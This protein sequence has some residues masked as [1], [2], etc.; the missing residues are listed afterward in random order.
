MIQ[1]RK[2]SHNTSQHQRTSFRPNVLLDASAN[3]NRPSK[4]VHNNASNKPTRP[5]TKALAAPGAPFVLPKGFE[6]LKADSEPKVSKL[7][8]QSKLAG[9]Q[10]WYITAP[11]SLPITSIKSVALKDVQKGKP[12]ATINGQSYGFQ[13]DEGP[14]KDNAKLLV[15]SRE[16]GRY[17]TS[18][19]GIDKVLHLQQIV[20]LPE[21]MTE[22]RAT[23]P[24]ASKF[25]RQQPKGLRMRFK[26]IGF[27]DEDTGKIG[28]TDNEDS[29]VEM[30]DAPRVFKKHKVSAESGDEAPKKSKKDKEKKKDKKEKKEKKEKKSKA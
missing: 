6:P 12:V 18:K 1:K 19:R 10:I 3:V 15:P 9:K 11:A 4:A 29:D 27:G 23:I 28:E 26:P 2:I 22:E 24:A 14:E 25:V 20:D 17:E 7:L 16:G 21:L 5:S 30:G 13:K 8:S